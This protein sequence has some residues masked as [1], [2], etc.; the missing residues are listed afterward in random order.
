MKS[1]QRYLKDTH[2][3]NSSYPSAHILKASYKYK[4]S[5]S[6]RYA[7]S[8]GMLLLVFVQHLA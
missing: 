1:R 3:F 5:W 2:L 4:L 6:N 7:S 8:H